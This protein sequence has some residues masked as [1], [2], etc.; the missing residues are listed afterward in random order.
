[1]K[2][3]ERL[4]EDYCYQKGDDCL[5]Q[6]TAPGTPFGEHI[7]TFCGCNLYDAYKAGFRKAKELLIK[8]EQEVLP[9]VRW[10]EIEL[11]ELMKFG[12][13]DV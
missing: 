11:D 8:R 10:L 3:L 13:E 1:M 7:Y 5:C 9:S 4:A 2:L 12:E 6:R